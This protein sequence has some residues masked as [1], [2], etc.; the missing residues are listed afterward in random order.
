MLETGSV[1]CPT[2]HVSEPLPLCKVEV[3]KRADVRGVNH[4]RQ[5][6]GVL[7]SWQLPI[8]WSSPK[9][10]VPSAP[11]DGRGMAVAYSVDVDH[12]P[13]RVD[14]LEAFEFCAPLLSGIGTT[15]G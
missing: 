13:N 4:R 3:R 6:Y 2:P 14:V 12:N 7:A 1:K 8:G 10:Q 15:R 9:R 11:T 5:I